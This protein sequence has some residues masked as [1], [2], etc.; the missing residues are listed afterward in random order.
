MFLRNQH[1]TC[2]VT[3]TNAIACV[4]L[5]V[6]RRLADAAIKQLLLAEVRSE[7]Q[8]RQQWEEARVRW[9]VLHSQHAVDLFKQK[10]S[11]TE[12]VE[13]S[14]R[15]ACCARL[16]AAQAAA[17]EALVAHCAKIPGLAPPKMSVLV[18]QQWAAGFQEWAATWDLQ[19][20][21]LQAALQQQEDEMEALVRRPG[22]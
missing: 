19:V 5:L 10:I 3:F 20:Q 11:G 21:Q 9:R 17:H 14:E 4:L 16:R 1:G 7:Q 12:F 18:V 6:C 2:N 15:L 22:S 13:P 8:Q